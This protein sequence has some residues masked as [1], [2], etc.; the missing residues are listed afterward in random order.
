M[1]RFKKA[2]QHIPED[3]IWC[4]ICK[5]PYG[6]IGC[7]VTIKGENLCLRCSVEREK[8][9]PPEKTEGASTD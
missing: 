4:P 8:A 9:T 5:R 6:F 1:P 2:S 3:W 7:R